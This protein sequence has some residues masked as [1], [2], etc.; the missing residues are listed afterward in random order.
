MCLAIPMKL[1]ESHD[2]SGVVEVG[3]VRWEVMLTFTPEAKLNDY[4]IVHAGYALEV[5]DQVEAERT[6][7]LFR[8]IEG[9]GS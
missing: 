1:V 7:A 8:E 6:L 5:L 4:L 9:V 2:Q 3:G